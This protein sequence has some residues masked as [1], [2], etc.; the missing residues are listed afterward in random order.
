[1]ADDGSPLHV[2]LTWADERATGLD[3]PPGRTILEAAYAAGVNHR[4]GCESGRCASC[5]GRLRRGAVTYVTEPQALS[6]DQR[7]DGFVLLCSATPTEPCRIEV[8][9]GV[10]TDA[11]PELW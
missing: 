4:S 9:T 2:E 7:D 6:A 5:V 8:G 1:M 10:L 11:F 3:V